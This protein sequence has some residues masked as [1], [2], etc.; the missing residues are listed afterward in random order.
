MSKRTMWLIII[1][2]SLSLIGAGVIQFIWFKQS[3]NQDEKNF[4]DKARQ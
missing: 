1:I 4:S 2:M 3:I